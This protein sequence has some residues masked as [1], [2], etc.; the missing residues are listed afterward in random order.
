MPPPPTRSAPNPLVEDLVNACTPQDGDKK[1][2][3]KGH[4]TQLRLALRAFLTNVDEMVRLATPTVERMAAHAD[5]IALTRAPSWPDDNFK[6]ASFEDCYELG[7]MAY[8]VVYCAAILRDPSGFGR[9]ATR[10]AHYFPSL[11]TESA[12]NDHS[13]SMKGDVIEIIKAMGYGLSAVFHDDFAD[14]GGRASTN[15]VQAQE[16]AT[17]ASQCF[18]RMERV[19]KDSFKD[20]IFGD[21]KTCYLVLRELKQ[22]PNGVCDMAGCLL[23]AALRVSP[24]TA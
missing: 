17:N 24:T 15:A 22:C 7:N 18:L 23:L 19:I 1:N 3:R 2:M 4:R 12:D 16:A 10:L 11:S 21:D 14:H 5:A 13:L 6:M 20:K 8:S 9:H